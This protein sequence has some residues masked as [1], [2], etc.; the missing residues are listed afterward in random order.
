VSGISI[1]TE[2]EA[3]IRLEPQTDLTRRELD[4]L[5]HIAQG[6]T[7]E[8]IASRLG[9]S[10]DT[11]KTHLCRLYRRLGARDRAHAVHLGHRRGLLF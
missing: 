2:G 7:N 1:D 6:R 8:D 9:V 4:M 10:V 5:R 3:F 11:V